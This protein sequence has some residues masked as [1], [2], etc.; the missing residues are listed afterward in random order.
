[1]LPPYTYSDGT[2][3]E[4]GLDGLIDVLLAEHEAREHARRYFTFIPA[5][6]SIERG[7]SYLKVGQRKVRADDHPVIGAFLTDNS[8][9]VVVEAR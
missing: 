8:D 7:F 2:T 3:L 1:M 5:G 6:G 4:R 9:V